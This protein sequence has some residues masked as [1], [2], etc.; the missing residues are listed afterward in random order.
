M[1]VLMSVT[2][3]RNV[4][5]HKWTSLMG[6]FVRIATSAHLPGAYPFADMESQPRFTTLRLCDRC[7]IYK[8][9]KDFVYVEGSYV[10]TDCSYSI[11]QEQQPV[12]SAKPARENDE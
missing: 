8:P 12:K 11:R 6:K 2:F 9:K 4:E 1:K 5:T 10:C 3:A 7:Q